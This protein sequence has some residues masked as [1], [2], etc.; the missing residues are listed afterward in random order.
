VLES[1]L[2]KL[3]DGT[4]DAAFTVDGQGLICSWNRAAEKLL[5]Y[6]SSEILH[7]PCAQLSRGRGALGTPVCR[8]PCDVLEC[9]A[10]GREVPHY[11]LQVEVRSGQR[12]WLNVSILVFHD[13]R[14]GRTLTV[15]LAHD[16]SQRKKREKM[17]H[18]V[19]DLTKQL[20]TFA[21]D[22]T[23]PAPVSPLAEQERKVLSLLS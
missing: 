8:E 18:K 21:S 23:R 13:D 17:T 4:A 15:H 14:T 3:L 2:F 9:G 5:G 12:V 22:G 10:A 20:V 11:D 16:I 19:L 1:E 7:K 6:T